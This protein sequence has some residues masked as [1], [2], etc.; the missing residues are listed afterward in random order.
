[1]KQIHKLFVMGAI[2]GGLC[3]F[4]DHSHYFQYNLSTKELTGVET[5]EANRVYVSYD[6]NT[7]VWI[8]TDEQG[9]PST[10]A[11]TSG[12]L[13]TGEMLGL[14]GEDASKTFVLDPRQAGDGQWT[15]WIEFVP[16]EPPSPPTPVTPGTPPVSRPPFHPPSARPAPPSIPDIIWVD[17]SAYHRHGD[18]WVGPGGDR[19]RPFGTG[20]HFFRDSHGT[21]L[22]RVGRFISRPRRPR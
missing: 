16:T 10:E 22:T 15:Y 7:S 17:G 12:Q 21:L 18:T 2:L 20:G 14:S 6:G 19:L 1:M 8:Q 11:L 3:A 4:G 9:E 13:A 5:L